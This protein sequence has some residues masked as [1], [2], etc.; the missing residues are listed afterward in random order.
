[1]SETIF[2]LIAAQGKNVKDIPSGS[3]LEKDRIF[4]LHR[5]FGTVKYKVEGIYTFK[6]PPFFPGQ[7]KSEINE[8]VTRKLRQDGTES[9]RVVIFDP[10]LSLGFRSVNLPEDN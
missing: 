5:L 8:V 2:N 4:G 7:P 1:M 3:I 9:K 6:Q 10:L